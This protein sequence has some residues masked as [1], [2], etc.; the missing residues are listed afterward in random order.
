MGFDTGLTWALYNI[1]KAKDSACDMSFYVSTQAVI[2]GQTLI[3]SRISIDI[4][5]EANKDA[6]DSA[7]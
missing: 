4:N 1:R 2:F 7:R 3:M 5:D 6:V